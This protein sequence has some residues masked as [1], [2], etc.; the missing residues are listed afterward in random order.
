MAA[1]VPSFVWPIVFGVDVLLIAF[2]VLAL[3]RHGGRGAAVAAVLFSAWFV[4]ATV[5][6][7]AGVFAGGAERP[8][9]IGMGVFPPILAGAVALASSRSLRAR[10]LAIPQP[11][12]VGIQSLRV[13][14]VVFLLLLAQGALPRQFALPAGWGDTAVGAAAPLVA[15]ALATRKRWA[16]RL[17]VAWNVLGLLDLGVAIGIGAL[18]AESSNPPLHRRAVDGRDGGSPALAH[19]HV[20]SPHLRAPARRLA[21]RA[22]RT[23]EGA[24]RATS[25]RRRARARALIVAARRDASGPLLPSYATAGLSTRARG[26]HRRTACRTYGS[27]MRVASRRGGSRTRPCAGA[28]T[29]RDGSPARGA[30]GRRARAASS[31]SYRAPTSGATSTNRPYAAGYVLD[32]SVIPAGAWHEVLNSDAV[33]Y[34]GAGVGNGEAPR[35]SSPGRIEV[36]VPACGLVVLAR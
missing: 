20:R 35:R 9:K 7:A 15:Y 28:G 6:A 23:S 24:T 16:P 13:I 10:V 14:G 17:A 5:L 33:A 30:N 1:L 36:V 32:N 4:L 11:W 2:V 25:P 27:C 34:G 12:L 8:P 21:A 26:A 19:P 3:R 22:S 29:R 18:S 31:R